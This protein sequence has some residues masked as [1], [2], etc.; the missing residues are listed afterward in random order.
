MS[1]GVFFLLLEQGISHGDVVLASKDLVRLVRVF[2]GI[3]VVEVDEL[4]LL[5]LLV[6]RLQ[7]VRM[8]VL[9]CL[10][11]LR[12]LE[13]R[14]LELRLLV[15]RLLVLRL[16][17]VGLLVVGLLVLRLFVLRLMFR[18]G[19]GLGILLVHEHLF[20]L[21]MHTVGRN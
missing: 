9:L 21:L 18:D 11:M 2:V 19:L 14:L 20:V 17:V 5:C 8:V 4:V 13:L 12:L 6:L 16:L 15:M 7:V 1:G 10:L 3:V